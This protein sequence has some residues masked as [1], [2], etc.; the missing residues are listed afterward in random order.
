MVVAAVFEIS[1]PIRPPTT[2]AG[3]PALTGISAARFPDMR[4]SKLWES[5]GRGT[6]RAVTSG[7]AGA[8]GVGSKGIE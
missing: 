1:A 2:V 6:R 8:S 7:D 5:T 4:P 3:T